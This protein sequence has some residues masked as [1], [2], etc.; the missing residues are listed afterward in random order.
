MIIIGKN[1]THNPESGKSSVSDILGDLQN[2]TESHLNNL[3]QEMNDAPSASPKNPQ[4]DLISIVQKLN[5]LA[6]IGEEEL[7][8][9]RQIAEAVFSFVIDIPDRQ[10]LNGMIDHTK[11]D[12]DLKPY[13]TAL[14]VLL[15][16]TQ[17]TNTGGINQLNSDVV[18]EL[19]PKAG[20]LVAAIGGTPFLKLMCEIVNEEV[21]SRVP[22][23]KVSDISARR[24]FGPAP[25]LSR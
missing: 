10:V 21:K 11:Y 1:N 13:I 17:N 22:N 4:A 8:D 24:A 16:L 7:I 23:S 5:F 20:A 3:S 9:A 2:K 14:N 15:P 19:S 6:Q 25:E 18:K 12:P